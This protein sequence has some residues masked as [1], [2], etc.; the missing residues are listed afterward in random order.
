[1]GFFRLLR[2]AV[3]AAPKNKHHLRTMPIVSFPPIESADEDGLLAVGGDLDPASLVLAYRSGIFPWPLNKRTLAWFAPPKRA[4][5]FLDEFHIS[6]RLQDELRRS[7]FTT[8]MDS[9]FDEVISRCAEIKNRGKQRATWITPD[10]IEAYSQ[11][12]QQ[13]IC[14]SAEAYTQDELVGGL[15]GV[16]IGRFF[17]AESSFYR[18]SNASKVAMVRLVEYLRSQKITW[19]DCQMLTPFSESFGAREISREEFMGLLAEA[20]R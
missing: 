7:R 4:V 6:R 12:F 14:H 9:R 19:F 20:T 17:A 2:K 11:L 18:I 1:M 15:Y 3:D 16:Q 8:R 13:G 5:I 10:I